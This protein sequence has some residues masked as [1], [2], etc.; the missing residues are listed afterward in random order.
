MSN[1]AEFEVEQALRYMYH[2]MPNDYGVDRRNGCLWW[3]DRAIDTLRCSDKAATDP[4][5]DA[6]VSQQD[7]GDS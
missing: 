5:L 1:L 7:A 4:Y 3:M 2:H 6:Q